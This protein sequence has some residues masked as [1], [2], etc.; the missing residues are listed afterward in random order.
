MDELV[1]KYVIER[2]KDKKRLQ[3]YIDK[4]QM[5]FTKEEETVAKKYLKNKTVLDV[6]CGTG[7]EAL[8]LSKLGFNVTAIDI[9]GEMITNAKKLINE[10]NINFEEFD[11]SSYGSTCFDNVIFFN[12]IFEQIPTEE[13][14][15][16]SIEKAYQLINPEGIFI[17]TT[18]SI[19]VPGPYGKDWAQLIG[20]IAKFYLKK[21]FKID[22]E[23]RSPLDLIIKEQNIYA[24]FSNP[25]K[26]K[27][28]LK[29]A[30]FSLMMVGSGNKLTIQKN[31]R[32]SYIFNEP[33]Y[34]ICTK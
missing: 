27:K 22:M 33:V 32:I 29:K 28:L 6:G 16:H 2:Y 14:R 15:I 12:N 10:E 19:F 18:H 9:S 25:F 3:G 30:G 17:L 4:T 5:G 34:Y 13:G 11:I 23:E 1:N 26:I 24:H 7:R 20:R 31:A 8:A 21:A